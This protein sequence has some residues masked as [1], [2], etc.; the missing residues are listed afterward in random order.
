MPN[1]AINAALG[2]LHRLASPGYQLPDDQLLYNF[3]SGADEAAFAA[4]VKRHGPMVFGVCQSVL[5]HAQDAE[6]AYQATFL[7]LARKGASIQ[8]KRSVAAWLHSVAVRLAR[9]HKATRQPLH[10]RA[11]APSLPPSPVDELS[12]REVRQIVHE[13]IGRLPKSYQLPLILC[14]L[15]GQTQDEAAR[16]LGWTAGTFKGRL[17]RGREAL[18]RNLT[19]RGLAS[20][21]PLLAAVLSP[22]TLSAGLASATARA[23]LLFA[24]GERAGA[25]ISTQAAALALEGLKAMLLAKLK[26]TAALMLALAVLTAGG[27]FAAH[28]GSKAEQPNGPQKGEPKRLSTAEPRTP[29]GG[30]Q[31]QARVDSYGDPLLLVRRSPP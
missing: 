10:P 15:E 28:W 11:S 9:K 8:K 7:M 20:A 27:G 19:R 14:Y 29:E 3:L 31:D 23:A 24:A 16:R 6:D 1:R 12:W 4:L 21:A 13:E 22:T 5:G 26:I 30:K 18:R 2:Q 17:D 25:G